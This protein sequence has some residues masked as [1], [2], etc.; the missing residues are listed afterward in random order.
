MVWKG[1]LK[2]SKSFVGYDTMKQ[3]V[4]FWYRLPYAALKF[5]WY[6]LKDKVCS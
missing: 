5:Y 2:E 1:F 6:T 4:I 3:R